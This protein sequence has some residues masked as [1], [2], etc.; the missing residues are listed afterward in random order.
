LF[1]GTFDRIQRQV[2]NQNCALS[3]CHDSQSRAGDLLL[4]D[5]AAHGNLVNVLP[6]NF[7]ARDAGWKRVDAPGPGGDPETSLLFR[8]VTGDL[9]ND[10]YGERMPLNRKKLNKTLRDIIERWIEAGAPENG[11]VPETN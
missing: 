8:K 4:E 1:D 3:G 6:D 5:T 10:A 2:F 11:W 9:P 7:A